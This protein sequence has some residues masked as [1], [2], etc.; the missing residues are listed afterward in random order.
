MCLAGFVDT[1][2]YVSSGTLNATHSLTHVYRSMMH[3]T[4]CMQYTTWMGDI[5]RK[6]KTVDVEV[7]DGL[8]TL[9][10]AVRLKDKYLLQPQDERLVIVKL[11]TMTSMITQR[12]SVAKSVGCFQRRLFVCRFVC[13]STR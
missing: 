10:S 5:N 11:Q 3:V 7:V 6:Y 1:L 2:C 8:P 13:L 12:R 4:L 9:Q